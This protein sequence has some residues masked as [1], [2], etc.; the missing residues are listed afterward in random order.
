MRFK[1][2]DPGFLPG[3][4]R[5]I[6]SRLSPAAR[7]SIIHLSKRVVIF[8]IPLERYA[9]AKTKC[10]DFHWTLRLLTS[11]DMQNVTSVVFYR[12]KN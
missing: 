3:L 9:R 11:F 4:R 2:K 10:L 1:M 6:E 8:I 12:S 5:C 7:I